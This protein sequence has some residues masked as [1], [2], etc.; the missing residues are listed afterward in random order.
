MGSMSIY[1]LLI[2]FGLAAGVAWLFAAFAIIG[3]NSK[4]KRIVQLLEQQQEVAQTEATGKT[5][6]ER[7]GLM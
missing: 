7:M 5:E 6:A 2:L 4:L 1:Q 3:A